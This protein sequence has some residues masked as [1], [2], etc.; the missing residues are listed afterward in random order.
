MPQP[1]R[2]WKDLDLDMS[3][4][5]NTK[6]LVYKKD[7]EAVKQSL[8]NILLTDEDEKHF[9]PDFGVGLKQML[10]EPMSYFTSLTIQEMIDSAIRAYEPRI[11]LEYLLVQ[12]VEE[13]NGYS[14]KIVFTMNNILTPIV[15]EYF[16]ERTR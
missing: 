16:L 7:S 11:N 5:P 12:P 13:E 6:D 8:K 14:I 3:V 10:F 1:T 2:R 15:V 9:N 4:H